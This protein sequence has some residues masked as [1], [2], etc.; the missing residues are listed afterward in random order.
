VEKNPYFLDAPVKEFKTW[1][2]FGADWPHCEKIIYFISK[3][4]KSLSFSSDSR[5]QTVESICTL[6]I[7]NAQIRL[8][9]KR[10]QRNTAG[11]HEQIQMVPI[12]PN[13]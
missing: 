8:V 1:V 12:D 6:E 7:M 4:K 5:F 13:I 2:V 11:N 10:S 3:E 9:P